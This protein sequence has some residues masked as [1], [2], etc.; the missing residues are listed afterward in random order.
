MASQKDTSNAKWTETSIN[1][2]VS[3]MVE[4][5]KK[6]N[7]ISCTFNKVGWK[8]IRTAFNN[9]I[10]IQYTQVQ[11]RNKAN[12]LRSQY[13]SFKKLLGQSGFGWDN[14]NKRVT[15]D[16][17]SIWELYVEDNIE[18]TK[19]KKDRFP[20]YP[21]LCIVFGDTYT[22]GEQAIGSGQNLALSDDGDNYEDDGNDFAKGFDDHQLDEEGFTLANPS[23]PV[24][25]KHNLD[26]TPN[27][28]RRK[29]SS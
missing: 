13:V 10:G 20:S 4:Q 1:L 18:W 28:K 11:L 19:F 14:V 24:H 9:K 21:E 16:N 12:K 26:R 15:I 27:T 8:N 7:R 2:F 25:D 23:T 3:L 5:L 29:K 17:P 22:T 6:G